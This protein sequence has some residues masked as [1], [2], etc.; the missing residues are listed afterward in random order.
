MTISDII[1]IVMLCIALIS[2]IVA[3]I[4]SI[5]DGGIKKFVQEKMIEAEATGLSGSE[6]L[7]YVLN[8]VKKKYKLNSLVE[9]AKKVIESFIDFSK[10]VNKK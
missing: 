4:K 3:L 2:A 9:I 6:K 10:K 7:E 5:L 1:N 8:A